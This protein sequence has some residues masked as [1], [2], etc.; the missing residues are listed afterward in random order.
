MDDV[1]TWNCG[2][3]AIEFV[4][5]FPHPHE[6]QIALRLYSRELE[7]NNTYSGI[8]NEL[9]DD[10]RSRYGHAS[11]QPEKKIILT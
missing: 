5:S 10:W 1:R 7:E 11:D 6:E 2:C 8:A 3:G 4:A 9:M